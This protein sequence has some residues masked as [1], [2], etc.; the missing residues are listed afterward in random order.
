LCDAVQASPR[1]LHASFKTI[2][3]A[4]PRAYQTALRLDA[5]RRDLLHASPGTTVSSVAVKWGF[6]QFGRFSG[7]YRQMFGEE[8][9]QTLRRAHSPG[10]HAFSATPSGLHG[11]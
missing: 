11:Q 2:F 1:S 4:T 6:F 7:A 9:R 3:N 5:A 10:V 8:P